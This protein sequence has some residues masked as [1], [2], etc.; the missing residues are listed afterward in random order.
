MLCRVTSTRAESESTEGCSLARIT[1]E[2]SGILTDETN[3]LLIDGAV[4]LEIEG[5]VGDH[6]VLGLSNHQEQV[7]VDRGAHRPLFFTK[8]EKAFKV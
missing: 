2:T 8:N 3:H 6:V 4:G 5:E 1:W 7:D